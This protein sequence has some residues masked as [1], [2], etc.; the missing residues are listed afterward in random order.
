MPLMLLG[1]SVSRMS[2]GSSM[3]RIKTRSSLGQISST[4]ICCLN[5]AS[6]NLATDRSFKEMSTFGAVMLTLGGMLVRDLP[7]AEFV[8]GI[9]LHAISRSDAL[10]CHACVL[11]YSLQR[12]RR[13]LR[14]A[15]LRLCAVGH[16]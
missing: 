14:H 3:R 6:D 9:A 12:G 11:A 16:G 1:L 15:R 4:P 8:L 10:P 2:L 7:V 13:A 5:R